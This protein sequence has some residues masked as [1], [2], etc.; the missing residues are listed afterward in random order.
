MQQSRPNEG[1]AESWN[2][3]L[4]MARPRFEKMTTK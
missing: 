1:S 3:E 4:Q 2:V